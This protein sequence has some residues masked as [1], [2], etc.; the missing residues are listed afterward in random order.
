M[1]ED[2]LPESL[3]DDGPDLL[4]EAWPYW[5][6]FCVLSPSRQLGMSVGSIPLSEIVAY[7]TLCDV[8]DPEERGDYVR[9]VQAID[10]VFVQHHAKKEK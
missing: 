5:Q 8:T 10:R 9:F 7:L 4:P 1:E 2:F 6:A 3:E